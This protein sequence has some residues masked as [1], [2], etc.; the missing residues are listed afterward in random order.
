MVAT[1][2]AAPRKGWVRTAAER[3]GIAIAARALW[4][5]VERLLHH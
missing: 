1:E 3:L 4:S 5:L 2:N